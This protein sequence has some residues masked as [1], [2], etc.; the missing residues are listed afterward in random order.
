VADCKLFYQKYFIF[1]KVFTPNMHLATSLYRLGTAY[2][3]GFLDRLA[4]WRL[5]QAGDF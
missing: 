1:F 3:N 4:V 5:A 2:F